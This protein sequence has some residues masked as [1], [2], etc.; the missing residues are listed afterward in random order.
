LDVFIDGFSYFPPFPY[1]IYDHLK[2]VSRL[3][4]TLYFNVCLARTDATANEFLEP[5]TFVLA[6]PTI[7]YIHNISLLYI[8]RVSVPAESCGKYWYSFRVSTILTCNRREHI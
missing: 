4:T 5:I 2:C 6:Y 7:F 3:R 8:L 1:I